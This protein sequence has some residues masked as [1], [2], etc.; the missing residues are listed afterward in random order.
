MR[1]I[2][3]LVF[4]ENEEKLIGAVSN[5]QKTLK[6][7]VLQKEEQK[8]KLEVALLK[9]MITECFRQAFPDAGE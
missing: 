5:L 3:T 4:V 2:L 1:K 9:F 7:D 8:R 6:A